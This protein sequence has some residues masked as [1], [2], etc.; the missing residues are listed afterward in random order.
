MAR[1]IRI[2]MNSDFHPTHCFFRSVMNELESMA[3][4]WTHLF[5]GNLSMAEMVSLI[6]AKSLTKEST[7]PHFFLYSRRTVDGFRVQMSLSETKVVRYL[8]TSL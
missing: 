7:L 3:M 2:S 5:R 8:W 4:K 1:S 6:L